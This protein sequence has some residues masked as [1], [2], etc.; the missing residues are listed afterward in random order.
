MGAKFYVRQL[1]FLILLVVSINSMIENT[2]PPCGGDLG[3]ESEFYEVITNFVDF[4]S[5]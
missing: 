4:F 5:L 1:D 2:P 3:N